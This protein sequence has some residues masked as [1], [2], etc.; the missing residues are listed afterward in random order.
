LRLRRGESGAV[1]EALALIGNSKARREDRLLHIRAFGEVHQPTAVPALLALVKADPDVDL[2]KAALAALTR[3]DD[4]TIGMEITGLYPNL[5]AALQT[6]AQSLLASRAAWSLGFLKLIEQG[7]IKTVDVSAEAIARLRQHSEKSVAEL[8]AKLFPKSAASVQPD[9]RAAMERI[10][11]TLKAASGNPYAGEPI[12]M[13][14]CAACHQLFHKGGSIGPNLT[15]YQ[16][17]DLNTMLPSIL[18]PSAEIREGYANYLVQ[19]K[20]GRALNGFLSDQD[21][22]VVVLRGFDGQDV[23][24]PRADIREMKPAGTS[25]MP[26]GLLDGL[27]EQQLRDLFAYLRIPQPISK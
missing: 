2:R 22:N 6:A 10:Q 15:A 8:T 11:R 27:G 20:D 17:D 7:A 12:F 9:T 25:L 4:A 16:R 3:Y 14:R 19:T 21:A 26:G 18:D 1:E 23:S 13:A 24:V 5:P